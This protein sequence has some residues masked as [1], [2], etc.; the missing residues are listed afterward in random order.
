MEILFNELFKSCVSDVYL[1]INIF[2]LIRL[3]NPVLTCYKSRH[4]TFDNL[5]TK[6]RYY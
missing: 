1:V 4:I 2:K 6:E 5:N 3:F